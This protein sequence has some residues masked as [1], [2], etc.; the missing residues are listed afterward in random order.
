MEEFDTSLTTNAKNNN[1]QPP[2]TAPKIKYE[3]LIIRKKEYSSSSD[4]YSS[5][6]SSN[7]KRNFKKFKKIPK[8]TQRFPGKASSN[9]QFISFKD[10]PLDINT[11]FELFMR[12]KR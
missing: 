4:L 6:K 7:G 12:S 11:Q 2:S 3:P 1:D 8:I 10:E 9:S 5:N